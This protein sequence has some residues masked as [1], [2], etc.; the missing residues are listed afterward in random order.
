MHMGPDVGLLFKQGKAGQVLVD[1]AKERR[2]RMENAA[3]RPRPG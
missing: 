3:E 2:A 1:I